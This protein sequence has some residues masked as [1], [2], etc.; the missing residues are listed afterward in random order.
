MPRG[1]RAWPLAMLVVPALLSGA[2]AT[3]QGGAVLTPPPELRP[4][5][6][7]S[8]LALGRRL[9]A[10]DQNA[11]ALKAF[12]VSLGTEG[13]SAEAFAGAGVAARRQGMLGLARRNFTR[14]LE[15][16]P[17]SAA[18]YNNLGVVL[19]DLKE[20]HAARAAFRAALALSGEDGEDA[21][22]RAMARRNLSRVEAAIARRDD[23]EAGAPADTH[24]L[25]RLGSDE[26]RLTPAPET[27]TAEAAD[28]QAEA[29]A[30][31]E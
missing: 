28:A 11:S 22:E 19:H 30:E 25:V 7:E 12:N 9:L 20:Y 21:G 5:A 18:G 2:C 16:E 15:L 8:Y 24:L 27:G 14:A 6:S 10:A 1:R 13:I 3:T 31:A 23:S 17:N 26:F 4:A 29:E